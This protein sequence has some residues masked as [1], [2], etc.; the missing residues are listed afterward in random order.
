MFKSV[1]EGMFK[2]HRRIKRDQLTNIVCF[3]GIIYLLM[4][5]QQKTQKPPVLNQDVFNEEATENIHLK[6]C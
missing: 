2:K 6:S 3:Q 5:E 4:V 1:T